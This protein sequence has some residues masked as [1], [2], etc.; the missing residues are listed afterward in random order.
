MPPIASVPLAQP[1][2]NAAPADSAPLPPASVAADTRD[3][4]SP[5][6]WIVGVL[7]VLG[8]GGA[9]YAGLSA[10]RRRR[11]EDEVQDD[12]GDTAPEPIPEQTY[13]EPVAA[14]P[15]VT[16]PVNE[17]TGGLEPEAPLPAFT[18]VE[19]M[20]GEDRSQAIEPTPQPTITQRIGSEELAPAASEQAAPAF[21]MPAGPV[22]QTRPERDALLERMVAAPPDS[23]NPF[24]SRKGRMRR[25]R[26]ILQ[27]LE[28]EQRE[29][30]TKPF[31]WRTYQPSTSNPA[32]ATPPRVTV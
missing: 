25:A 15:A 22:P 28:H 29:Q 17:P 24:T 26:L 10:S 14:E 11:R 12:Y 30:A 27:R 18:T 13:V 21:V 6:A 5:L 2:V 19:E 16:F 7:V 9:A 20:A 31:D 1:A 32:P 4:P 3:G 8:L 23:E